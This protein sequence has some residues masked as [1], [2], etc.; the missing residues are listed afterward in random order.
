MINIAI[1]GPSGAGKST[2]ADAIAQRLGYIHVD[3]GAM[4]RTIG[5]FILRAGTDPCDGKAVAEMLP[6]LDMSV[7]YENGI[8]KMY[9]GKED[10]TSAIR[11]NDVSMYASSVSAHPSVRA[12]LLNVQ[13]EFAKTHNV[14]MDGRDIG[15]VILPDANIK[16]F[17]TASAEAR[18]DRRHK[19]LSGRGENIDYNKILDEIKER[20]KKDTTRTIAP[21]VPAK[22]AVML[23]NSGSFDDVLES[24]L[25]IIKDK[26]K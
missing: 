9:L 12:F 8:Q 5:L 4:Y 17:M 23:D 18:A 22:D 7:K 10:V 19:E 6:L 3:T 13:R 16:F 2:L 14:I 24:A 25:K 26:I 20:D 1:D 15:T 21:A 11:R